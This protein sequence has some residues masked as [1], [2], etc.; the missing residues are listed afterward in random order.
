M[1]EIGF[2]QRLQVDAIKVAK[3]NLAFIHSNRSEL[4][5]YIEIFRLYSI[6]NV[7]VG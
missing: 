6:L 2:V 7:V 5:V 1:K 3:G 4:L